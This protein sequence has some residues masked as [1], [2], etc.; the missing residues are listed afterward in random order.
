MPMRVVLDDEVFQR[1]GV[2]KS[3]RRAWEKQGKFPRRV[4]LSDG[5]RSSG[6]LA[7]EIDAWIAARVA[8]RDAGM[9]A[10]PS[11][12]SAFWDDVK[13]GRRPHPRTAGKLARLAREAQ[14]AAT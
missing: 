8:A 14:R 11:K 10:R 1:T 7:E 5:G 4:P 2:P 12:R 6:Y 13:A 9:A 3:T